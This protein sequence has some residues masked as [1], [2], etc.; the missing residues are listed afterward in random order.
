M[1]AALAGLAAFVALV[2]HVDPD[3]AARFTLPEA[4]VEDR[5]RAILDARG[6]PTP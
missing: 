3:A 5:A 4:T 1:L 6:L 2:P